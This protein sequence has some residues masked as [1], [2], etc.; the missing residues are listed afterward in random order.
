MFRCNP[1]QIGRHLFDDLFAS[2]LVRFFSE[3]NF[4]HSG[5]HPGFVISGSADHHAVQ[6][7]VNKGLGLF[8]RLDAAVDAELRLRKV[9]LKLI[10]IVGLERGHVSVLTR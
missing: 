9:L 5:Q 3:E 2:N 7:V 4:V 10:G 6:T 8:Q 1:V